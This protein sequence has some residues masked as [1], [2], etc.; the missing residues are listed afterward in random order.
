MSLRLLFLWEG[1]AD[2]E[3]DSEILT[4]KTDEMPAFS[5]LAGAAK[6]SLLTS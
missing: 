2:S 4:L 5:C 3:L 6:V 1:R